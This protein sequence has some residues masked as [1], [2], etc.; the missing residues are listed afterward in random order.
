[1]DTGVGDEQQPGEA[2]CSFLNEDVVS[3]NVELEEKQPEENTESAD[4]VI[5]NAGLRVFCWPGFLL[6]FFFTCAHDF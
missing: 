5:K 4:A 2:R 6:S 1:M 3:R